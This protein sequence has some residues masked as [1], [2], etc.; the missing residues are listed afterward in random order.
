MK[1]SSSET[2]LYMIKE[3]K[4]HKKL[5]LIRDPCEYITWII[6]ATFQDFYFLKISLMISLDKW[7]IGRN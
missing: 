2:I 1:A 6:N 3:E 7:S 4:L 5:N